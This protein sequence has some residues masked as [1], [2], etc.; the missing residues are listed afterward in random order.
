MTVLPGDSAW[1][2]QLS[3][4]YNFLIIDLGGRKEVRSVATQGHANT[5]NYVTEYIIQ[6]S[7]DGQAWRSFTDQRGETEVRF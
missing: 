7:D 5:L 6:F 3:T 4:F 1:S 2:P